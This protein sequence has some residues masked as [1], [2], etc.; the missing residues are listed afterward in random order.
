MYEKFCNF[1]RELA[2]Y[3]V[4]VGSFGRGEEHD[5]SDIDCYLR[6]RPRAEVNPEA[7]ENNETYMP[8][9]RELVERYGYITGS[10]IAGH[11]A[12]ERQPEVP[13]MVE[14]SSHYRIRST[15][16]VSIRE[17]YGVPFLCAKDDKDAPLDE[18]Y[19]SAEWAE[20]TCDVVIKNPLPAYNETVG[21]TEAEKKMG[22]PKIVKPKDIELNARLDAETAGKLEAICERLNITKGEAIRRGIKALH[23]SIDWNPVPEGATY[24]YKVGETVYAIVK[25]SGTFQLEVVCATISRVAP[26]TIEVTA[27]NS[28]LT[29]DLYTFP[30][31][32]WGKSLFHSEEA[33]HMRLL[34]RLGEHQ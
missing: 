3:V 9:V 21:L 33:A 15:E 10:V 26:E 20:D 29:S 25:N 5:G 22:R 6:S 8:E 34:E 14:V 18:I 1:L 30:A 27:N 12:V 4:V 32:E 13:R 2:P 31:E 16:A 23:E 11:I 28:P 17:I 24:P 19:E 7:A